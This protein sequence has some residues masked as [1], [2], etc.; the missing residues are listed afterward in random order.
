MRRLPWLVAFP[1]LFV[2]AALPAPTLPE[3]LQR[4]KNE[5]HY[6]RYPAALDTLAA[7]DAESRKLGLEKDREALVPIIAFYRGASLA[8]L[9]R[10]EQAI[11]Q[12]QSFLL[13]QPNAA[14]DPAFYPRTVIA[15]FADARKASAPREAP[16][17]GRSLAEAFAAFPRPQIAGDE[18]LGEDW[19]EGPVRHLL[20]SEDRRDFSRLSDPVSRAEFVSAFW[21]KRDPKPETPENEFREDFIKRV[22]FADAKFTEG[23]TPG[24]RTDLGMVFVLLGP[25]TWI[26]RKP[27]V[28]GEDA[29]TASNLTRYR[30]ADV[31]V[32][33]V[34]GGTTAARVSRIDAV[35]GPGTTMNEASQ[36]W[37][38]VWH[39]RHEL[40]PR[41][42]PYLQ[43]DVEFLTK[44]GYGSSVLQR[45]A[46]VLDTLDRAR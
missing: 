40:L 33:A 5:F 21:K 45:E 29:N 20:N 15:A 13:Y 17:P 9:G 7:L 39:Y 24:S 43:V 19:A 3:L 28:S 1:L 10:K 23:E 12:L 22:A 6:G 36:D 4:V 8:A 37:R 14:L 2:T 30:T 16:E 41:G 42:T 27:F 46:V 38:E 25:P 26:G 32:A 34:P 44:K 31:K 11:P 18:F 35:T